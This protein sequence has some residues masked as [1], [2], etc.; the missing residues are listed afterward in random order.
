MEPTICEPREENYID[1]VVAIIAQAIEEEG[2]EYLD[3]ED[4]LYWCELANLD[5]EF[6][7]RRY[8]E[9]QAKGWIPKPV[10]QVFICEDEEEEYEYRTLEQ[11]V[12]AWCTPNVEV[13]K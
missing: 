6:A 4:G 5:P 10:T 1:L 11:V 3:T 9:E 7:K 12:S 8:R 13:D 2:L